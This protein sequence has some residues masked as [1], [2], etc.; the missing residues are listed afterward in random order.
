MELCEIDHHSRQKRLTG[1]LRRLTEAS[2]Q[3]E[4]NGRIAFPNLYTCRQT[5]NV[6]DCGLHQ[7]H[8]AGDG[9]ADNVRSGIGI[10]AVTLDIKSD[11]PA[12]LTA[13]GYGG[14]AQTEILPISTLV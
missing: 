2:R 1:G 14:H 5:Q 3:T 7:T 13:E 12:A 8:R 10:A 11:H 4:R 6:I 9:R